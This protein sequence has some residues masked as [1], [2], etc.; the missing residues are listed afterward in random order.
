MPMLREQ[1]N[2][3]VRLHYDCIGSLL[4][5]SLWIFFILFIYFAVV[6]CGINDLGRTVT[7]KRWQPLSGVPLSEL[8]MSSF[9]L[10]RGGVQETGSDSSNGRR[11]C[12][13]QIYTRRQLQQRERALYRFQNR[14]G[15]TATEESDG[16][17]IGSKIFER[18]WSRLRARASVAKGSPVINREAGTHTRVL[19]PL[20]QPPVDERLSI[21]TRYEHRFAAAIRTYDP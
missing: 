21:T 20:I 3:N 15:I 13:R 5:E 8:S 16:S 7:G 4:K 18:H 14:K 19:T 9:H 6:W 1:I 10:A 11:E 12:V 17:K 2:S